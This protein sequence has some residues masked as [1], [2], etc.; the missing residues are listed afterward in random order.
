MRRNTSSIAI[1]QAVKKMFF[2][3]SPG[4]IC[5]HGFE[6]INVLFSFSIINC[7]DCHMPLL[8]SETIQLNV[9]NADKP[10][11]DFVRTHRVAIYDGKTK[12]YI[13]NI[14]TILT[15]KSSGK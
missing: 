5:Q 11:P 15:N 2:L 8:P 12:E 4:L 14:K 7:I 10:V 9:A 13:D 6:V 1:V 3:F